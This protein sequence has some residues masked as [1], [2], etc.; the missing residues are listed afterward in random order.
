MREAPLK[1]QHDSNPIQKNLPLEPLPAKEAAEDAPP[2]PF[3]RGP[4][5]NSDAP[6][7][8]YSSLLANATEFELLI[9]EYL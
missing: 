2:P 4:V 7:Y 9:S 8:T 5:V 3:R 1:L 6:F